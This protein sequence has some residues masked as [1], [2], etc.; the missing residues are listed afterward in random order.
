MAVTF[1]MNLMIQA[2]MSYRSARMVNSTREHMEGEKQQIHTEI[3]L[4]GHSSKAK[5]QRLDQISSQS[6]K[7]DSLIADAV[8]TSKEKT[9]KAGTE[10]QKDS[11]SSVDT[12]EADGKTG[13]DFKSGE[14]ILSDSSAKAANAGSAEQS[15]N[16]LDIIV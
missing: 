10:Q 9:Q 15:Q 12:Q 14:T 2:N 1:D 13:G 5:D 8:N 11:T 3:E 4:D 16:K 7:A 6:V